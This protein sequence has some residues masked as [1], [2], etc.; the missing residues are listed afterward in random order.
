MAD[1]IYDDENRYSIDDD[2]L[3][4]GS[5]DVVPVDETVEDLDEIEETELD[6]EGNVVVPDDGPPDNADD[7]PEETG[8]D[9]PLADID[10][11]DP[12][13]VEPEDTYDVLLLDDETEELDDPDE[14]PEDDLPEE[15]IVVEYLNTNQ[16]TIPTTCMVKEGDTV[17][18]MLVNG[19]PTVIGVVGGDEYKANTDLT[20][21]PD[22]SVK[23][24]HIQDASITNAKI[25]NAAIDSAKIGTA[26]IGTAHIQDASITN[27]K[28]QDAAI[29]NAKIENAAINTAKIEDAAITNAKIGTA[30]IKT[31]NIE[32]GSITNAKIGNAAIGT[33]NIQ[34]AAI[35][36]AKIGTAAVGTANI[37]KA[38]ITEAEIE[39]G[40]IT[41]AKIG[42]AAITTAKIQEGAITSATIHDGAINTTKIADG[43]I[44]NAKIDA[45]SADKITS[46]TIQT[47]RLILV[48]DE[49]GKTSVVTALNAAAEAQ[50]GVLNGATI[51]DNTIEAAKINVADLNA[52]KAKIGSFDIG[53]SSIHSKKEAIND[54]TAGVYLGITGIGAG[55]GELAGVDGSPLEVYADGTFKLRGKNSSIIFDPVYGDIDINA[56]SISIGSSSVASKTDL[57]KFPT[58]TYEMYATSTSATEAPNS[59]WSTDTP[60]W[61]EG[62]YIWRRVMSVYESGDVETGKPVMIT[63]NSGTNGKDGAQGPAGADGPQGPQGPAGADGADAITLSVTTTNGNAFNSSV[64]STTLI[65]HVFVSGVELS[66]TEISKLGTIV[67][68]KTDEYETNAKVST[69]PTLPIS[70]SNVNKKSVY[71]VQLERVV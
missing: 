42:N 48:D 27:A 11:L 55:D 70:A 25:A 67:W 71:T 43:S 59:G 19:E 5:L 8:P 45:L 61:H 47:E 24:A 57:E 22:G 34:D 65:A 12:D 29:T 16:A 32:D 49:T 40:A 21:V 18:I 64:E 44:T 35:T 17:E 69:G 6:E 52:F 58:A 10:I 26:V 68:Y 38:A 28:I 14:D 13:E 31:A 2:T 9:E 20:N 4:F 56:T 41:N 66:E 60:E 3:E 33:A 15:D 63:G 1:E 37:Q 7:I 36:N 62:I 39:D 51:I 53:Q 54:P 30:A 46:G 50:G 23:T